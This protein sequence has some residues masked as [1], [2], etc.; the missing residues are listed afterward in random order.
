[1]NK[2]SNAHPFSDEL[3]RLVRDKPFPVNRRGTKL[4]F[5][6]L[7]LSLLFLGGLITLSILHE[8]RYGP[9]PAHFLFDFG[10]SGFLVATFIVAAAL[11]VTLGVLLRVLLQQQEVEQGLRAKIALNHSMSLAFVDAGLVVDAA[12]RILNVN[13]AALSFFGYAR[14]E[15]LETM[16]PYP[17]W[18]DRSLADSR[19]SAEGSFA[20]ENNKAEG[21]FVARR[22]NGTTFVCKVS[23]SPF[24][25]ELGRKVGW[26]RIYRDVTELTAAR[27]ELLAAYQ[28]AMRVLDTLAVGI[29]VTTNG[30]AGP[31][32]LFA[33]SAYTRL[34]GAN[35][36]DHQRLRALAIEQ[37]SLAD[38]RSGVEILDTTTNHWFWL[39]ASH[40]IWPTGERVEMLTVTDVSATHEAEQLL[41]QQRKTAEQLSRLITMGEMASSIA[42][43]LNQPLA[44]VQNYAAGASLMLKNGRLTEDKME[45]AFTK[46]QVQA[47]RAGLIMKRIRDFAR[48]STPHFEAI[49]VQTLVD[50]AMELAQI[51]ARKFGLHVEVKLAPNLPEVLCDP[52]M[53]SQV[54]V[55]L[56]RNAMQA[57]ASANITEEPIVLSV[58]ATSDQLVTFS[59]ADHGPGVPEEMKKRLFEPFFSTKKTGLGIGL[60]ICRSI[61]E[62]HHDRLLCEDNPG[63]GALFRFSLSATT[64]KLPSQEISSSL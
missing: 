16:P 60:N 62:R 24:T 44:A 30:S 2:D 10:H 18:V 46:I 49:S 17:F 43:E 48:R 15:L 42:H 33:N 41:S 28:R 6:A 23:C 34:F 59:V 45:D 51:S 13:T 22:K 53:I 4:V 26:L 47:Q 64:C 35:S 20:A 14:C 7:L 36:H 19:I 61:I 27:E 40:I 12:G 39:R 1:M 56:L 11:I 31:K 57:C 25:D 37:T 58:S 63:G 9:S 52:V 54:L 8:L 21:T 32:T 50:D 29:S 55:N 3:L 38:L 5:V